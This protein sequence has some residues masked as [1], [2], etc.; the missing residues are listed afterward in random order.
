MGKTY[1]KDPLDSAYRAEEELYDKLA[2]EWALKVEARS[3]SKA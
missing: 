1:R 3:K 2:S